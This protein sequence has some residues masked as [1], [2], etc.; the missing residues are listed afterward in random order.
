MGSANPS[1][2]RVTPADTR[3]LRESRSRARPRR[4][5]VSRVQL[6]AARCSWFDRRLCAAGL[7]MPARMGGSGVGVV[8]VRGLGVEFVLFEVD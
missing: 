2:A 3:L 1:G 4:G 7:A 8:V 5:A 6:T